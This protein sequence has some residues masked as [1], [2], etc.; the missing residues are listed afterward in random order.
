MATKCNETIIT[1]K[2]KTVLVRGNNKGYQHDKDSDR[3]KKKKSQS[4][5][6]SAKCKVI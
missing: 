6:K 3:P 2:E 1:N 5:R 4:I